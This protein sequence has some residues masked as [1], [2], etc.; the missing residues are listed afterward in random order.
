MATLLYNLD[1]AWSF[2]RHCREQ[3]LD[4]HP[5]GKQG[6]H[7]WDVGQ[8]GLGVHPGLP[9]P[10]RV[11]PQEALSELE[12]LKACLGVIDA[13]VL[14]MAASLADKYTSGFGFVESSLFQ[15]CSQRI[16][17]LYTDGSAP[18]KEALSSLADKFHF[19]VVCDQADEVRRFLVLR[20][21]VD[22]AH[23]FPP[24]TPGFP[25]SRDLR[26]QKWLRLD[27]DNPGESPV[28][29][30][31]RQAAAG[32]R[33]RITN[34]RNTRENQA[35]KESFRRF[36][37]EVKSLVEN[38]ASGEP[39]NKP[40]VDL[41]SAPFFYRSGFAGRVEG[42]VGSF[43][44]ELTEFLETWFAHL[45]HNHQ[46]QKQKVEREFSGKRDNLE[47]QL[48]PVVG[49]GDSDF[50]QC[51]EDISADQK[52]LGQQLDDVVRKVQGDLTPESRRA[53]SMHGTAN[54]DFTPRFLPQQE[55]ALEEALEQVRRAAGGLA[56]PV[57]GM[58]ALL[59]IMGL[60]LTP[61]FIL[62][63]WGPPMSWRPEE[64]AGL[65]LWVLL[66]LAPTTLSL[67]MFA[68][69]RR[70]RMKRSLQRLK[71]GMADLLE[72]HRQIMK[73][74]ETYLAL[75]LANRQMHE[76]EEIVL[77]ARKE[78]GDYREVVNDIERMLPDDVEAAGE[79]D[80]LPPR[81]WWRTVVDYI[82]KQAQPS[83]IRQDDRRRSGELSPLHS[84]A[85]TEHATLRVD[86]WS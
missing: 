58:L 79:G 81:R 1:P 53:V 83:D 20:M 72:R 27:V 68:W 11:A 62:W 36:R 40:A 46:N 54:H 86:E 10:V 30:A 14:C 6:I 37:Q 15:S 2:H 44:S 63:R 70:R 43:R 32:M 51:Q 25:F 67:L 84:R 23:A 60:A 48:R 85:L 73:A 26:P 59:A 9:W 78:H 69:V 24:G 57:A 64:S 55:N 80:D 4:W 50:R 47:K 34:W 17:F 52:A 39:E 41:P 33:S 22:T 21:T 71:Q 75:L 82:L 31:Y 18:V 74:T 76:L 7:V 45:N 12:E 28:A 49:I 3:A 66:F 65:M 77:K 29:Q 61:A 38:A 8:A 5:H 42:T 35:W 13:V 56:S 19:V 16:L